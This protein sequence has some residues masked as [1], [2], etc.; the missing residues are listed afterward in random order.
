MTLLGSPNRGVMGS[1]DCTPGYYNNEGQPGPNSIV[2]MGYPFGASA[3]F[4]Y[5]AEW[6]AKGDFDGVAF[7]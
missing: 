4:R 6:R 5:I 7:S 1:V 2:G 3:Y